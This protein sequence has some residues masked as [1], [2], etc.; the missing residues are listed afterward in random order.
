VSDGVWE[1]LIGAGGC[2]ELLKCAS[3]QVVKQLIASVCKLRHTS[4]AGGA[5]IHNS[6]TRDVIAW[7][8]PVNDPHSGML[9]EQ[10]Q[11][12]H[13]VA[14]QNMHMSVY[15]M[16]ACWFDPIWSLDAHLLYL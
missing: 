16:C 5:G 3:T 1:V 10:Q 14:C 11:H 4:R 13:M 8:C 12:L 2:W 7:M 9:A 15:L 6:K